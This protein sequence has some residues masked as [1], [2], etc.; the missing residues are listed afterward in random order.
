M[1]GLNKVSLIGDLGKGPEISA[2]D[3]NLPVAKFALATTETWR[4]KA[5]Q[6]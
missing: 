1:R 3:G 4:D 5:G 6:P 2:L